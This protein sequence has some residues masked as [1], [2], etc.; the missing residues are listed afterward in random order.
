MLTEGAPP[1]AETAGGM[2]STAAADG[3]DGG[4][5]FGEEADEAAV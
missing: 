2:G 5:A 4:A 3:D 1:A